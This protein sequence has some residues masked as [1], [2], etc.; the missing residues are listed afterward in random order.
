MPRILADDIMVL[1]IGEG[2]EGIFKLNFDLT[3]QYLSDVGARIAPSR[4]YVFST[5]RVTRQRLRDHLWEVLGT[6]V[7]VVTHMRDLGSHLSVGA[8]LQGATITARLKKA[9][10][11]VY[12]IAKTNLAFFNKAKLIRT[13]ALATGLYGSEAAPVCDQALA[14]LRTAIARTI[15]PHSRLTNNAMKFLLESHGTDLD[16]AVEVLSRRVMVLKRILAK[17]SHMQ[18]LV[19]DIHLQYAARGFLGTDTSSVAIGLLRPAPPPGTGTRTQWKQGCKPLG[20]IG[21]L[22]LSL[23]EAAASLG[24]GLAIASRGEGV[25]HICT[26]PYHHLR[27]AIQQLAIRARTWHASSCRNLYKELKEVDLATLEAAT[28]HRC[29]EDKQWLHHTMALGTWTDFKKEMVD[30]ANDGSCVYCGCPRAD[31]VHLLWSCPRFEEVRYEGDEGLKQLG[32]EVMP[33]HPCLSIPAP[34]G[35]Q[36]SITFCDSQG[37]DALHFCPPRGHPLAFDR[38][39][40]A[41]AIQL[42]ARLGHRSEGL[43]A[44]QLMDTFRCPELAP[45]LPIAQPCIGVAPDKPNVWT[46]GTK[47]LPRQADWSLA[48]FGLWFPGRPSQEISAHEAFL[49][50]QVDNVH[51]KGCVALAGALTGAFS[52]STRAEMAGGHV[53]IN[54][55]NPVHIGS[56]SLAFCTKLQAI[57]DAPNITPRRPWCLHKDGDFW[58]AIAL[59]VAAKGP[60]AVKVS[61]VKGHAMLH[62]IF[63]GV[64]T[65]SS[66]IGNGVAD[67][68]ADIGVLQGVEPGLPQ[69]AQY[70]AAKQVAYTKLITR[71]HNLML[72][73]L[74]HEKALREAALEKAR[75]AATIGAGPL[76]KPKVKLA[77]NY[78]FTSLH[79]GHALKLIEPRIHGCNP[80]QVILLLHLWVFFKHSKWKPAAGGKNGSSWMEL[81]AAFQSKGGLLYATQLEDNPIAVKRSFKTQ[82]ATFKC[83]ARSFLAVHA[84]PT[85]LAMFKPAKCKEYRLIAYGITQHV[86]CISAELCLLEGTS[87]A[88]MHFQLLALTGHTKQLHHRQASQGT[89]LSAPSKLKMR[90]PPPWD[91]FCLPQV[92]PQLVARFACAFKHLSQEEDPFVFIEPAPVTFLLACPRCHETK[93]CASR[94]LVVHSKWPQLVCGTC[95]A[96]TRA[97]QWLC[98]CNEL[99][100]TCQKHRMPGFRCKRPSMRKHACRFRL[101]KRPSGTLGDAHLEREQPKVVTRPRPLACTPTS[102]A[103]SSRSV[104]RPHPSTPSAE[105][106]VLPRLT[107][108][109][110]SNIVQGIGPGR[111]ELIEIGQGTGWEFDRG[112]GQGTCEPIEIGQ[113]TGCDIVLGIG[114][115]TASSSRSGKALASSLSLSR[116]GKA[117]ASSSRSGKALRFAPGPKV[118]SRIAAFS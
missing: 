31:I 116:S 27:V 112:I 16:P 48:G 49:G 102:T 105:R 68:V 52:S 73:V 44:R 66:I 60:G 77:Q 101:A 4:S 42:L 13:V 34:L 11:I 97:N 20:P 107:P 23:H 5:N 94:P 93:E 87:P 76:A 65:S 106:I 8:T 86:P 43:N 55:P 81:F 103:F 29:C 92:I 67:R 53:A 3:H 75:I 22:C 1:A 45:A 95:L 114:Q 56:D 17:H 84:D 37:A 57:L 50:N 69:L 118:A 113:G 78:K 83:Q 85:D 115:G 100:H 40:Q 24:K 28:K 15:G 111:G 12:K 47:T 10:R 108:A 6:K 71:T 72:R 41:E 59:S 36:H 39:P 110:G 80:E 18:A 51:T 62:H 89:L 9:C 98:P 33:L 70:Y 109:A 14:S 88:T 63:E 99:W 104:K 38:A 54:S 35:P 58:Q 82:L 30:P 79:E 26:M 19:Q 2:H 32:P 25:I 96:T 21:L 46:D 7:P 61:W 74:T 90:G 117:L 64:A 91:M